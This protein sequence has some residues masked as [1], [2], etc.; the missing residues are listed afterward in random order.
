MTDYI[1]GIKKTGFILENEIVT[2]LKENSWNII[3]N[4]YYEDDII[5]S[6]REID[7]LAYKVSIRED[8]YYYTTLIISCKKSDDNSWVLVSRDIDFDE[9]NSNWWPLHAWTNDVVL[10]EVI[11][12]EIKGRDYYELMYDDKQISVMSHPNADIFA[13]QEM[14]KKNGRPQNDKKI[15]SSI[16]SLMKAQSYEI[17]ALKTRKKHACIYQFNLVSV[18]DS[19]LIRLHLN[20]NEIKQLNTNSEE[21]VARYIIKKQEQ[22][23]RIRFVK[24]SSFGE[25]IKDYNMLHKA[26]VELFQKRRDNWFED[27]IK[28]SSKVSILKAEFANKI[29]RKIFLASNYA[30]SRQDVM[31]YMEV[32][33]ETGKNK[34]RIFITEDESITKNLNSN[35]DLFVETKLILLDVFRYEGKFYFSTDSLPF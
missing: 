35:E 31:D 10:K 6:I 9:P 24:A 17:G 21:M 18:I 12:H 5:E 15:F 33:W 16:T 19:E 23:F 14:S 13:F 7:I 32:V 30:V 27:A 25:Y 20:D 26:N 4:K 11:S 8:I 34:V 3:S 29:G 28:D 2:L 1:Q 22:F